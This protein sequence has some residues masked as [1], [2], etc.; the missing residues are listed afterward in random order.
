MHADAKIR[1]AAG[2]TPRRKRTRNKNDFSRIRRATQ[3]NARGNRFA[4]RR[5]KCPYDW[6]YTI[7]L[8]GVSRV[9]FFHYSRVQSADVGLKEHD[10]WHGSCLTASSMFRGNM[11]TKEV[12][13]EMPNFQNKNSLYFVEWISTM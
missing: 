9:P 10:V 4:S 12:D 6:L 11:S 2:G 3:T 13:E 5:W 1:Q 8:K 7:D